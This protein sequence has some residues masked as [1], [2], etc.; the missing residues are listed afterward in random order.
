M[1]VWKAD[2]ALKSPRPPGSASRLP[3]AD[4]PL[5]SRD[6]REG[7]TSDLRVTTAVTFV[8]DQPS[9]DSPCPVSGRE[10]LPLGFYPVVPSSGGLWGAGA[11]DAGTRMW[12]HPTSC[13]QPSPVTG[14][15]KRAKNLEEATGGEVIVTKAS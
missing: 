2:G 5:E 1:H 7:Q 9:H 3:A 13:L 10:K 14:K 8:A 11:T 12:A 6:R 4:G 15:P